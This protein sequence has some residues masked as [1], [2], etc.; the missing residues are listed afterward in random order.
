M[1]IDAFPPVPEDYLRQLN[2]KHLLAG[3]DMVRVVTPEAMPARKALPCHWEFQGARELLMRAGELVP[4]EHA[5]RRVLALLN[6]GYSVNRLATS[7]AIF[8]GLQ[9]LLPGEFAPG[10]RHSPAAARFVVEGAGA[11]TIVDG[12]AYPME[13]GDLLLT[14]QHHWHEHAHNGDEPMIWMDILDHP[15]GFPLETAYLIDSD[16]PPLSNAPHSDGSPYELG[17]LLPYRTK[18]RP[19]P[20]YPICRY[21]WKRVKPALLELAKRLD[22]DQP[23]HYRYANPE[24]GD[25]CL[26][27]LRFSV[28]M[29]R[30]GES[31][32]IHQH[33]SS[34]VFHAVEGDGETKIDDKTINWAEKDVFS[35]PTFSKISHENKGDEPAFLFQIDDT[36]MQEKLGY[37]EEREL[38]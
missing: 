12:V 33:S 17:G 14:P 16:Q 29:L 2:D 36:P 35:A 34:A 19:A 32:A 6:P 8:T 22:A 11:V 13:P 37:Y 21:P 10:H 15:I 24:T 18:S 1:T 28:R 5:E 26:R 31:I 20:E 30:N 3:W 27:T 4:M 9:L 25:D 7:P 23:I 38:G